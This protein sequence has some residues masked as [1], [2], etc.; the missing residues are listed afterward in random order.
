[1]ILTRS[2]IVGAAA[3]SL[4]VTVGVG[5]AQ[6]AP[7][8]YLNSANYR[9]IAAAMLFTDGNMVRGAA[10]DVV[11]TVYNQSLVPTDKFIYQY[12][13]SGS[14][15]YARQSH[16][17]WNGTTWATIPSSVVE[18]GYESGVTYETLRYNSTFTAAQSRAL[19]RMGKAAANTDP[20]YLTSQRA[21]SNWNNDVEPYAMLSLIRSHSSPSGLMATVQAS[22]AA[23]E[24]FNAN[25][26]ATT[27]PHDSSL[28]D[29]RLTVVPSG[30]ST[31]TTQYLEFRLDAAHIVESATWARLKGDGGSLLDVAYTGLGSGVTVPAM[32]PSRITVDYW[33]LL[34]AEYRILAEDSVRPTARLIRTKAKALTPSGSRTRPDHVRR[35]AGQVSRP[36]AITRTNTTLGVRLS[37]RYNGVRGSLCVSATSTGTVVIVSC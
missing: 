21:D 13:G 3:A 10:V 34:S 11:R 15:G 25:V 23:G 2:L 26:T 24:Y 22:L 12:R 17:Y 29:Y 14:A 1:M 4:T 20:A 28:V 27:D 19:T 5:A 8:D 32:D 33:A 9:A 36:A 31:Y 37:T 35:A 30:S 7:T 6:A 18:R 16:D